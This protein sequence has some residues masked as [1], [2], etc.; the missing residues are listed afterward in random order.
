[1][2]STRLGMSSSLSLLCEMTARSGGHRRRLCVVL[3]YG[4]ETACT[5]AS[6]AKLTLIKPALQS[7][8]SPQMVLHR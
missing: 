3:Q 7:G 5:R 1:M 6:A 8:Q 2:E 4:S